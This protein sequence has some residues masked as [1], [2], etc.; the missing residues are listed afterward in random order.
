MD[1][2]ANLAARPEQKPPLHGIITILFVMVFFLLVLLLGVS[3]VHHR[4][5]QGEREHR[6]GSVGQ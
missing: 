6:N 4:F 3:M 5:F 1:K 2:D